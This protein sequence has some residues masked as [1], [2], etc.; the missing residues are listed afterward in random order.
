MRRIT[1]TL[2]L[3]FIVGFAACD[4]TP[5]EAPEQ[6]IPSADLPQM[7]VEGMSDGD[8]A[9]VALFNESR[10]TG[11]F[12]VK[13]CII[14]SP[15][16][17]NEEG[18]FIGFAGFFPN[19]LF[20]PEGGTCGFTRT[21][22]DGSEDVHINARGGLFLFLFDP[23][24]FFGSEGSDVK[25]TYMTRGEEKAVLSFNGTLSD[26]SRVRGHFS[27]GDNNSGRL[28]VEGLGYVLGSPGRSGR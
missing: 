3:P 5:T 21:N 19:E 8:A 12:V 27:S 4:S 2:V 28:W 17:F 6:L 23:P 9:A 10:D 22:P 14:V 16:L 24:A 26:G 13:D 15:G 11:A 7:S 1:S 25:W 20:D 18:E